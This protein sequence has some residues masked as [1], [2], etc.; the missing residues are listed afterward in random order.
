MCMIVAGFS[1]VFITSLLHWLGET[2]YP[3][4]G[5]GLGES[6]ARPAVMY[7]VAA[8]F[9]LGSANAFIGAASQRGSNT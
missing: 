9:N 5:V 8:I 3:P 2:H 1:E 7:L 4:C 6:L